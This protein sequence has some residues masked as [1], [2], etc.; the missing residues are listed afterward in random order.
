MAGFCIWNTCSCFPWTPLIGPRAKFILKELSLV[1]GKHHRVMNSGTSK[2][3]NVLAP[4]LCW[5]DELSMAL[6][7]ERALCPFGN[8]IWPVDRGLCTLIEF[9]S[10]PAMLFHSQLNLESKV[11][12][13]FLNAFPPS[14]PRNKWLMLKWH[15]P[16]LIFVSA[17][18]LTSKTWR[19]NFKLESSVDIH[20]VLSPKMSSLWKL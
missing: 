2:D 16:T 1:L 8:K 13:R 11:L 9:P 10:L 17:P 15:S 7:D 5:Y 18:K 12:K 14:M 19:I 6:F 20:C 3:L 4:A